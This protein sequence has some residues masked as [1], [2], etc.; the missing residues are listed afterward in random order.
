MVIA[1]PTTLISLL[2]AVAFGWRQQEGIENARKIGQLGG[3]L[4]ERLSS[5]AGS[6]NQLGRDIERCGATFNRTV[7]TLEKR[8]L[9]SAR[10]LAA[11][12]A[13]QDAENP[14]PEPDKTEVETRVMHPEEPSS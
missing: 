10:K 1:T 5:M 12:G 3:E 14:L 7:G 4:F 2:R 11:L 9:V 13:A 6:L 8:V